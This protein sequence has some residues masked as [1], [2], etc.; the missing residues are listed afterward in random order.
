MQ[1]EQQQKQHKTQ[2]PQNHVKDCRPRVPTV[3]WVSSDPCSS[4]NPSRIE[5]K[6][7]E[8]LCIEVLWTSPPAM[9]VPLVMQ[10]AF[11][12]YQFFELGSV[13]AGHADDIGGWV[14]VCCSLQLYLLAEAYLK[15]MTIGKMMNRGLALAVACFSHVYL[16][17]VCFIIAAT[18]PFMQVHYFL[19]MICTLMAYWALFMVPW[20]AIYVGDK[21]PWQWT[22]RA[23]AMNGLHRDRLATATSDTMPSATTTTFVQPYAIR[24]FMGG[25]A[26]PNHVF[27]RPPWLSQPLKRIVAVPKEQ[28]EHDVV[29]V[30]K[31]LDLSQFS[32]SDP[33]PACESEL[34]PVATDY[35]APDV[36]VPIVQGSN[37]LPGTVAIETAADD[38]GGL[39]SEPSVSESQVLRRVSDSGAD[40]LPC[41]RTIYVVRGSRD[42]PSL[43]NPGKLRS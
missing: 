33:V 25:P 2:Q 9:I 12:L 8:D 3:S 20:T 1:M 32:M 11:V 42:V 10:A 23:M 28:F 34:E 36:L 29:S 14:G 15:Y 24:R 27:Q 5:S 43:E 7:C 19:V 17:F 21:Q 6:S 31:S 22:H 41:A 40:H 16:L 4:G 39:V 18:Q 35:H 38:S 26:D 37:V 30:S 13:M